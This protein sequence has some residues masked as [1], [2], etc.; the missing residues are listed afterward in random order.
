MKHGE[1]IC[2]YCG[3]D[4]M[5]IIDHQQLAIGK[6]EI[7]V[8]DEIYVT[9]ECDICH[10]ECRTVGQISYKQPE[11]KQVKVNVLLEIVLNSYIYKQTVLEVIHNELLGSHGFTSFAVLEK[12][13]FVD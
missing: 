7:P 6:T 4:R 5:K 12:E 9:L 2:P 13:S 8:D 3:S 1:L 11:P 10:K